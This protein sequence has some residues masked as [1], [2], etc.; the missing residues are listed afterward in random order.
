[1]IVDRDGTLWQTGS[2]NDSKDHHKNRQ[3]TSKPGDKPEPVLAYPVRTRVKSVSAGHAI[4]II[5]DNDILWSWG[6]PAEEKEFNMDSNA[7]ADLDINATQPTRLMT[8]VRR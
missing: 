5:D 6:D 7:A 1:M 3:T 4:F 2:L 8:D